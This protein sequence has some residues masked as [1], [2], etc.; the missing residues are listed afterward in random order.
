MRNRKRTS[1][2]TGI[3][4]SLA[5]ALSACATDDPDDPG[6]TTTIGGVTT[7]VSDVTTTT[8]P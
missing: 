2:V 5:L 1:L 3:V 6:V 7:T 8:L 4:L